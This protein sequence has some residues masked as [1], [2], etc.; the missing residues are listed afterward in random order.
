[1]RVLGYWGIRNLGSGSKLSG[2][3]SSTS[4]NLPVPIDIWGSG[5][6]GKNSAIPPSLPVRNYVRVQGIR[7]LGPGDDARV[8]VHGGDA[9]GVVR[10]ET[11]DPERTHLV[12]PERARCGRE[13]AGEKE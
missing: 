3:N 11:R 4:H 9:D 8:E 10:L 2:K 12:D 5:V 7:G 13:E 6:S 1:M